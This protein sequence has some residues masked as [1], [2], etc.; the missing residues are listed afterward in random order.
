M[1]ADGP[2]RLLPSPGYPV[3][4]TANV[5]QYLDPGLVP[6]VPIEPNE[7]ILRLMASLGIDS[8][9]TREVYERVETA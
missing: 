9:R 7:Q 2:P 8:S 4:P 5:K 3:L 6:D 1:Q